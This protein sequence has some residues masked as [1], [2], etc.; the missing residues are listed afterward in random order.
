[1]TQEEFAGATT[2]NFYR[3]Y[4]KVPRAASGTAA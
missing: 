1:L 2:E 4:T 3:L